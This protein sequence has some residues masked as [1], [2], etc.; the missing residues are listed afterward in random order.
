MVAFVLQYARNLSQA[1]EIKGRSVHGVA[2]FRMVRQYEMT[3]EVP[4]VNGQVP[5]SAFQQGVLETLHRASPHQFFRTVRI[6]WSELWKGRPALGTN[7]AEERSTVCHR[8]ETYDELSPIF[9]CRA[10]QLSAQ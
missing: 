7:A 9:H 2:V 5:I 4:L 8:V 6:T 1:F 10:A 3:N